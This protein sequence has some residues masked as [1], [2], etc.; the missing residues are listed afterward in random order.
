MDRVRE[1]K[2][3]KKM[4]NKKSRAEVEMEDGREEREIRGKKKEGNEE[5]K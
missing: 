3:K 5:K 4:F 1:E 2:A